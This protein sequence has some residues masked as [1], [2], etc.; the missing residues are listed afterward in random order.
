MA[1]MEKSSRKTAMAEIRTLQKD[2]FVSKP[3]GTN[4]YEKTPLPTENK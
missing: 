3:R 2:K 1:K 4:S